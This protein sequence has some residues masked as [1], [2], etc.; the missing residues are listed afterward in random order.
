[1]KKSLLII[2]IFMLLLL[3]IAALAETPNKIT[4][5]VEFSKMDQEVSTVQSANAISNL[6]V[7][8][9]SLLLNY[10]IS[11]NLTPYILIGNR[12]IELERITVFENG[13]DIA[14]GLGAKGTLAELP[15]NIMLGYDVRYSGV[16]VE[17]ST[18]SSNLKIEQRALEA[19]LIASKEI[20]MKKVVK[21]LTPYVGYKFTELDMNL[22]DSSSEVNYDGDL[23]SFLAGCNVKITDNI[24]ASI[25]GI[26]GDEDGVIGKIAYKF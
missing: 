15:K 22:S 5:E 20:E 19:S 11:Q 8:S 13:D 12:D 16:N 21:S 4:A 6:E 26:F 2:S 10:E 17:T 24:L 23:N 9:I 18:S 25:G 14:L 1:M 7:E 3:P